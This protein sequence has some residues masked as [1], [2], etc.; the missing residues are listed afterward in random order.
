MMTTL[1]VHLG[2]ASLHHSYHDMLSGTFDILMRI[3]PLVC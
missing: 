3:L 1:P 2:A